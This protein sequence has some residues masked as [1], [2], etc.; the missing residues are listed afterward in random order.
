M[1]AV[2]VLRR[3]E[4]I[5][6]EKKELERSSHLNLQ[7]ISSLTMKGGVEKLSIAIDAPEG[8]SQA[9]ERL[10][11]KFSAMKLSFRWFG[12]RRTLSDEQRRAAAL[13]FGA[14]DSY[15]SAAKKLLDT[16]HPAFRRVSQ[17]RSKAIQ[18][19]KSRSLP[20]PEP[21][22]RLIGNDDI[23]DLNSRMADLRE[24]L[25]DAVADLGE[26]FTE[27]KSAARLRLGSL[28]VEADYPEEIRG[29]FEINWEFPSV[30][31]PE[32][33]LRLSPA[34]YQQECQRVQNQF[35]D[36]VKL[37]EQA[38]IDEL[39][40]LVTRLSERLT[41]NADGKPKVFRDSAIENLTDFLERFQKLNI[42]SNSQLDDLV[43][44][45]RSVVNGVQPQQLRSSDDLRQKVVTQLSGIQSVLE[46]IM[47]DR[48]R[49][50][51]IRSA[52]QSHQSNQNDSSGME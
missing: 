50:R 41:G 36:A 13:A 33:L 1:V 46:G 10:R 17:I 51:I 39:S 24:E 23:S 20:F 47:V 18:Y 52:G 11:G 35:D 4:S 27:L 5:E 42:H 26:M 9:S 43:E 37:A 25:N 15:L 7:L 8:Q 45:A 44:R 6:F 12:V 31:P 3:V 16:G 2:S 21:G 19:W 40:S 34:I 28:F 29:L 32:Y 14:E 30:E 49:R 48:P 22:I 38:F